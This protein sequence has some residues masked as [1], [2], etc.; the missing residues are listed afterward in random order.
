MKKVKV[1]ING[2]GRIGLCTARVIAQREDVELVAINTTADIDTLVHLIK[3]DSVHRGFEVQK[4]NDTTISMGYSKNIKVL[5]SRIPQEIG[6]GACGVEGVIECT[7][8][9][10]SLEKSSLHLNGGV[11]KVIISAPADETPTY[12]YGVNH[13]QYQGEAVISNASCTTNCLAPIVQVLDLAFGIVDGLMTTV[14]SY[15][16]DQ[17]LLDVRHKDIRRAR[18]AGLNTIPTSTGAA[19]AVGLVLPHLNGKLNGFAIRVPTPDVSLVDL[20]VNLKQKVTPQEVNA[21]MREVSVGDK[22]G[23]IG[24]DEDKCV[25]SDFIGSSLSAIFVPDKTIVVGDSHLKV[26]AWYDNEM[27]YCNRLVDMS[28][29]TLRF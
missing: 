6:F 23:I 12:V 24:I 14:H 7:G 5:S 21:L 8:A 20:S 4:I 15:T 28:V 10:N 25:S 29:Y 26:L 11:Q 22:K 16:N 1:G 18:A 2:S 19:K 17:N 13:T 9:F 27:G 3:Y